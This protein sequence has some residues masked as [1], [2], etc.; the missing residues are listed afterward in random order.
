[1]PAANPLV[2]S[3]IL[4]FVN[5]EGLILRDVSDESTRHKWEDIRHIYHF[6]RYN[7]LSIIDS[8]GDAFVGKVL[9]DDHFN[10]K[11]EKIR[12]IWKMWKN[13]TPNANE[14]DTFKYHIPGSNKGELN[15]WSILLGSPLLRVLLV[16]FLFLSIFN[17]IF[18]LIALIYLALRLYT[19]LPILSE[20]K[21]SGITIHFSDNIL[22]VAYDDGSRKNF[23]ISDIK[24][25]NLNDPHK[26][27]TLVFTDGTKLKNF[28]KLSH[29]VVLKDR[30]IYRT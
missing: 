12:Y 30:L 15:I 13:G 18:L 20:I 22:T 5:E 24:K 2:F 17:A 25:H 19:G 23:K 28:D 26:S 8:Q 14:I 16:L 29:W 9:P 27:K 1:M 21:R 4:I 11:S 10:T 6:T 7:V 3:E